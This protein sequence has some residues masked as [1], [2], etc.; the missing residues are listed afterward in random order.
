MEGRE[1]KNYNDGLQQIQQ[2]KLN[3]ILFLDLGT[4]PALQIKFGF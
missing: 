4:S 2:S 3:V 1:L